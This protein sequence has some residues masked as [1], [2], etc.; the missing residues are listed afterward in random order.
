MPALPLV[1]TCLVQ[2]DKRML[3]SVLEDGAWAARMTPEDRRA[4]SPL[5]HAR[6]DPYG[7]FEIDLACRVDFTA[8]A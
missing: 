2:V 5:G 7:R 3:R 8:A 4:L 1:R 6:I